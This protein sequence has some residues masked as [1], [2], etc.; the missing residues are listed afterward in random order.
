MKAT[1]VLSEEHRVIERVLSA[2]ETGAWLLSQD[3]KFSADFF[4]QATDFIKGFADGCHHRKEEGVL[5]KSMI[6]HGMPT[7]GSPVAAM[8]HEHEK[9][10]EYTRALRVAAEQM[11][12]GSQTARAE[13]VNNAKYYAAL[14]RQHIGKEDYILFPM[15]ERI[16]PQ[17]QY[18]AVWE[19]FEQVEHTESGEGVHEK[20]L[21]LAEALEAQVDI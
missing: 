12:H 17:E 15:A 3:E 16:I 9:G 13:V 10:R 4:I 6:K 2:L 5:F 1:Q 14:L 11:K 18:D 7:E 20:Y 19:Q 8:L 21:A